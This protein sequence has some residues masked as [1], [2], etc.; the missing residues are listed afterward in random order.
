MPARKPQTSPQPPSLPAK[1]RGVARAKTVP[2]G[3]NGSERV[4]APRMAPQERESVILDRAIEHFAAEGFSASTRELAQSIGVTHSLLYKY[5]PTKEALL[6]KVYERV[7]LARMGAMPEH[8]LADRS[9]PI[10]DRLK[11]YYKTYAQSITQSDWVRIF[12]FAGL[13]G[14]DIHQRLLALV[15]ERIFIPVMRE[16]RAELELGPPKSKDEMEL[17]IELVWGLHASIF[18]LGIRKWIYDVPIPK[19][20]DALIDALVEVFYLGLKAR[21]SGLTNQQCSS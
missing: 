9:I 18:Y 4:R 8:L 21:S 20:V 15:R 10:Q 17:Q 11:L 14:T 13:K 16:L 6:D 2:P 12:M 7:Y 3:H 5:F 19:D 1:K